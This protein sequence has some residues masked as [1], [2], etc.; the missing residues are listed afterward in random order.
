MNTL[1]FMDGV[2]YGDNTDGVG[3]IR[4][5]T[6]NQ[7]QAVNG[8]S[9][10]VL[11]AGGAARGIL[12]PLLEAKPRE[13][14][15]A[16][17]TVERAEQLVAAVWCLRLA[18]HHDVRGSRPAHPV[19]YLDQRDVGGSQGRSGAVPARDRRTASRFATTWS[20]A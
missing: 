3:F 5:V 18:E 11:G 19:R 2:L 20:T 15:I 6:I 13:L 16:N 8:R 7:H 9:V 10:L 14:V 1:S 17:R 4:D 12:A